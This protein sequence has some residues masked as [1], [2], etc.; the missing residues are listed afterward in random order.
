MQGDV[1]SQRE[2]MGVAAVQLVILTT[3]VVMTSRMCVRRVSKANLIQ[4]ITYKSILMDFKNAT[5]YKE[6]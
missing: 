6:F 4:I 3:A 5:L 1:T 2:N